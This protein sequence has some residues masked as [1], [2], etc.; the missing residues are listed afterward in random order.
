MWQVPSCCICVVQISQSTFQVPVHLELPKIVS[1]AVCWMLNVH[2]LDAVAGAFRSSKLLSP[3]HAY[4]ALLLCSLSVLTW[5]YHTI[6]NSEPGSPDAISSNSKE[7][8]PC[9]HCG[10]TSPTI[11]VR[12]D[13]ATGADCCECTQLCFEHRQLCCMPVLN[14]VTCC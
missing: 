5:M 8:A 12:H 1:K 6:Y 9:E 11:R 4:A 14:S 10:M 3:D 2:H 13:F 7:G